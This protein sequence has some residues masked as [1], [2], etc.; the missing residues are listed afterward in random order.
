MTK[1]KTTEST[2]LIDFGVVDGL[3]VYGN[4][5]TKRLEISLTGDMFGDLFA[6]WRNRNKSILEN[7]RKE[8]NKWISA[9]L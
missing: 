8:L 1:F 2:T 7:C 9:Q 4:P 6:D 3:R 5:K